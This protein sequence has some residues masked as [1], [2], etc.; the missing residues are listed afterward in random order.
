MS[1]MN[2]VI[3][4]GNL[5]KDP[6]LKYTAGGSAVC[7]MS[8]ALN[9]TTG[10]GADKKEEVSFIDLTAFGK[11]AENAAEYLKKGRQVIV[12]GRLQQDRWESQEGQKRSKVKVI[13]E[14]LTFVGGGQPQAAQQEDL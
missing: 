7:D 6:E 4:L 14:R 8:L 2:K 10:K 5:T 3:L 9:Y 12:E 11:T 13:V 1:S